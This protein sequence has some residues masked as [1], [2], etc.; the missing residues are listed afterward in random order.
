VWGEEGAEGEGQDPKYFSL[1]PPL[2]L[3]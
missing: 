3:P 1:E 2:R